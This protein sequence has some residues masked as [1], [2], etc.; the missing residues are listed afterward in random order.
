MLTPSKIRRKL[1][2]SLLRVGPRIKPLT[3]RHSVVWEIRILVPTKKNHHNLWIIS[4]QPN[5]Q[6]TARSWIKPI[7]DNWL[8]L[9][10][11][12]HYS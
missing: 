3:G 4:G 2:E 5:S 8:R 11:V 9:L 6:K 1:A 7:S 12:N 10:M